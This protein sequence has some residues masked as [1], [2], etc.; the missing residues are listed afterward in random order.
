MNSKVTRQMDYATISEI[1][2]NEIRE[3]ILSGKFE[4]GERINQK[5][6]TEKLGISI[7]P[8]V[9]FFSRQLQLTFRTTG[10]HMPFLL[11][12]NSSRCDNNTRKGCPII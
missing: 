4:P 5:Q 6:L 11:T 9:S 7:I 8:L 1:A 2:F 10:S 3:A 12:V